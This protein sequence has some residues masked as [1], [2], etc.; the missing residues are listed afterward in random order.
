MHNACGVS[1]L[2]AHAM[3]ASRRLCAS[4]PAQMRQLAFGS[5]RLTR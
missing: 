2:P 3:H 4:P 1:L 5:G